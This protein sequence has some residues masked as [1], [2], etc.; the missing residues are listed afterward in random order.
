ML[1]GMTMIPFI[2]KNNSHPYGRSGFF[3]LH[4][5]SFTLNNAENGSGGDVAIQASENSGFRRNDAE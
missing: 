4:Q 3:F 5:E 2:S 1:P